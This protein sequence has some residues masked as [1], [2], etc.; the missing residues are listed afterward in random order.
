MLQFC[1]TLGCLEV[2]EVAAESI[3]NKVRGFKDAN[4]IPFRFNSQ[5]FVILRRRF[6]PPKDLCILPGVP[7]LPADYI[8]P[9]ACK[10]RRPQDDKLFIRQIDARNIVIRLKRMLLIPF[11][12]QIPPSRV[13]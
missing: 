5:A 2:E 6:L 9:S 8:D 7:M 3:R 1:R 13:D 10:E 4:S 11:Q 12:T